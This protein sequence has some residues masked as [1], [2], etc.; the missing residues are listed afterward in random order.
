L[1]LRRRE[2]LV[3]QRGI[4]DDGVVVNVDVHVEA[5]RQAQVRG[6]AALARAWIRGGRG[7]RQVNVRM[8]TLSDRDAA[9]QSALI[10]GYPVVGDLDVMTPAVHHDAAAALRT[11]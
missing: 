11:V 5:E 4:L 8:F 2:Q 6:I 10:V 7:A 9:R 1:G 3:S